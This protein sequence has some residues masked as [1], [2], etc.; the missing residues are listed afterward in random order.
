M[1]G[2]R[3][4]PLPIGPG[5]KREHRPPGVTHKRNTFRAQL[6][7]RSHR[8]VEPGAAARHRPYRCSFRNHQRYAVTLGIEAAEPHHQF[9][10]PVRHANAKPAVSVSEKPLA[11][12]HRIEVHADDGEFGRIEEKGFELGACGPVFEQPDPERVPAVNAAADQVERQEDK[13]LAQSGL[14]RQSRI[15]RFIQIGGID[16]IANDLRINALQCPRRR[17]DAAADGQH[18]GD[19]APPAS[20]KRRPPAQP[21]AIPSGYARLVQGGIPG[22]PAAEPLGKARRIFCNIG[23]IVGV[24]KCPFDPGRKPV[25]NEIDLRCDP[26]RQEPV[27]RVIGK[28]PVPAIRLRLNM[29]PRHAV[30]CGRDSERGEEAKV[31]GPAIVVTG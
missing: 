10:I 7:D 17:H 21:P 15:I 2:D 18:D 24:E 23:G 29:V 4:T 28:S 9:R 12:K 16:M 19:K 5:D 11:R 30:T 14:A 1:L 6:C 31:V 25:V 8:L 26:E 13:L 20:P 3:A 22:Y 27:E